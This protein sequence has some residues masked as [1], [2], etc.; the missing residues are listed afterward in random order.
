M[1]SSIP[2]S[3]IDVAENCISVVE[4]K[5][6]NDLIFLENINFNENKVNLTIQSGAFYQLSKMK[7]INFSNSKVSVARLDILEQ[8][9]YLTCLDLTH[10]S[11]SKTDFRTSVKFLNLTIYL[12]YNDLILW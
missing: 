1:F 2:P 6:F 3:Y 12:F 4:K 8:I 10:N 5:A 9:D 7:E 11:I